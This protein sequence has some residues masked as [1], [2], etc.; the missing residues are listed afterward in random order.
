MWSA[1]RRCLPPAYGRERSQKAR[2]SH[3]SRH[4]ARLQRHLPEGLVRP[5]PPDHVRGEGFVTTPLDAGDRVGGAVEFAGIKAEPNHD[6]TSAMISR[7]KRFL[8]HLDADQPAKRWMGFRPSIPD[9]LP[10]IGP[11][12]RDS[13]VVY[14]FGHGHHGLTQAAV[15]SRLVANLIDGSSS[16]IDLKPFS[17]RRF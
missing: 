16:A 7:L 14:A 6:R 8:P 11:A 5:Q 13:R 12:T 15:T 4:R 2:G 10:V 17:A 1:T 3:P 9:S